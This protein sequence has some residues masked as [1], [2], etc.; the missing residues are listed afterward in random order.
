MACQ[1]KNATL[2]E[3]L[4]ESPIFIPSD[5]KLVINFFYYYFR[6]VRA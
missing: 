2:V 5:G 1:A 6:E 4:D 3:I